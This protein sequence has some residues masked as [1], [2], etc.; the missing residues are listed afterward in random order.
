MGFVKRLSGIGGIM[1]SQI[2]GVL[3]FPILSIPDERGCVWKM[4]TPPFNV[5]DVYVTTI[6][7]D[8]IK[9]WHGYETKK[10]FYTVVQGKVKLALWDGRKNSLT[11]GV[12]DELFLG[13]DS[14]FSVLIPPGVYAGFKGISMQDSIVV[15]QANEP[16][17]Q[18]YRKPYNDLAYEWGIHH[19]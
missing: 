19:G 14:R 6:H 12:F 13:D 8:A 7:K 4:Q 16:Y 1:L 17:K 11:S 9:A 5:R 2:D 15:V 18:I 3:T 10:I